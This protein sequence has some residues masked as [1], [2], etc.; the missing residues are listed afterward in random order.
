MPAFVNNKPSTYWKHC[1]A[2]LVRTT[3]MDEAIAQL[4]FSAFHLRARLNAEGGQY[5]M[6]IRRV[7]L[8]MNIIVA[9]LLMKGETSRSSP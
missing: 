4:F 8:H 1:G 9:Y 2:F 3:A 7:I 6:N 5:I